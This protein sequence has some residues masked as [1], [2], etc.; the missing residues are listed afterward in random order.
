[1]LRYIDIYIFFFAV[2]ALKQ[3]TP[4]VPLRMMIQTNG[5]SVP[6]ILFGDP[7]L[8]EVPPFG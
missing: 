2:N 1:M 4:N 5:K 7:V 6:N 3:S 8:L